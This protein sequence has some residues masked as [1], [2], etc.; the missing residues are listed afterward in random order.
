MPDTPATKP[1]K[2]SRSGALLLSPIGSLTPGIVFVSFGIWMWV[3]VDAPTAAFFFLLAALQVP[4]MFNNA[5]IKSRIQG[6]RRP[7][8]AQA[9]YRF[10]TPIFA[11]AAA[12][13]LGVALWGRH[14]EADPF[15][16][17]APLFLAVSLAL[18]VVL[19]A[20]LQW[21][22]RRIKMKALE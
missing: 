3:T 14:V 5:A 21:L 11:T 15:S 9:I 20:G 2:L 19:A 18:G 12:A 1:R 17:I 16:Q 7:I 4:M 6:D 13:F 22:A 10:E 8:R